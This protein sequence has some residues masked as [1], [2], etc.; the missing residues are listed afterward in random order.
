M[1]P[2]C[3]LIFSALQVIDN[4]GGSGSQGTKS[5]E[6][7]DS[8]EGAQAVVA[9]CGSRRF[10]RLALSAISAVSVLSQRNRARLTETFLN[11]MSDFFTDDTLPLLTSP[12]EWT[13]LLPFKVAANCGVYVSKTY[14]IE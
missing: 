3:R 10:L 9:G 7:R 8:S 4:N 1:K 5:E 11:L 2:V 14:S 6:D 13:H 12:L